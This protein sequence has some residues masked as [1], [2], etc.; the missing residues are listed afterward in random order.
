MSVAGKVYIGGQ[1]LMENSTEVN[2]QTNHKNGY[3]EWLGLNCVNGAVGWILLREV[4]GV[5]GFGE[6]NITEYGR[7]E[8]K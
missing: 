6:T 3:D 5:P 7:A 8:D 4:Q 2:A 1:E